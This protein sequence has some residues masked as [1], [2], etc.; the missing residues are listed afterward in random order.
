[1]FRCDKSVQCL[2]SGAQDGVGLEALEHIGALGS[3]LAGA[4]D[5]Y[6]VVNV[7]VDSKTC[8]TLLCEYFSQSVLFCLCAA[9]L[10]CY[11][12]TR[13]ALTIIVL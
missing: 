6:A 2:L 8:P 3:V 10:C 1:M 11:H 7:G 9:R 5:V 4:N 12:S 13:A